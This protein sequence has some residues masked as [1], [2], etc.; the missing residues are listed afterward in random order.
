MRR[1]ARLTSAAALGGSLLAAAPALA[2]TRATEAGAVEITQILT[3]LD[4]PWALGFLPGGGMLITERD[5][6]LLHIAPDGTRQSVSGVPEVAADGQG[7]LLD[8]LV[9]RDFAQSRQI[10][11]TFSKPQ[12]RGAGTALARGVLSAD[13]AALQGTETLWESA[14]GF[15]GGRHFGSRVV[16]G[17]DG[18]LYL[19]TGDRGDRP[20]AQ[21]TGN[22]NG[23]VIRLT[24]D[25]DVPSSNP[26]VGESGAQPE[27]YT[28]GHRNPQ[29]AALD[30]SGQL[31]T[32][33]HGA[34]GGDEV[35]LIEAGTNYGWPVISYGRHYSGF[36]IGEGTEAPGL[37]QPKHYWDPSIAPSGMTFV[38]DAMF[39]DWEGDILV[40]S[41]NS[42][43]ISR[44]DVSGTEVREVE[45]IA[46][47]E[48]LRIR[49]VRTGPDGDVWFLSEGN[50]A[51]YRM[52]VAGES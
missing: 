43:L 17:R 39:P 15:S 40:G 12:G 26:L 24:R 37:A 49:D 35:N 11:L 25:G 14:P 50:G 18:L 16:E 28:Y 10:Y 38:G 51:L 9:P 42:D 3:G 21:D 45:R 52:R 19:T 5:G 27:I 48:T 30:A 29:G 33:E 2:E 44:L 20:S 1:L 4:V 13:G 7:G 34:R 47:P 32:V 23:S 22:H 41:L 6:V 36:R 46:T 8:V 31:W